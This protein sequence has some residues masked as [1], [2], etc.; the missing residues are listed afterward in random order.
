MGKRLQISEE[1]SLNL[2]SRKSPNLRI[3]LLN[4]TKRLR[5]SNSRQNLAKEMPNPSQ[6]LQNQKQNQNQKLQL[7]NQKL[8]LQPQPKK[9]LLPSKKFIEAKV[10]LKV[11]R[12]SYQSS[13]SL[14]YCRSG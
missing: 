4:L 12:N 7:Q 6:K 2:P 1:S 9:L 5:S 10:I 13:H 14:N 3:N 8:Q 11:T